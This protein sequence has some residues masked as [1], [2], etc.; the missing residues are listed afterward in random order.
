MRSAA[1]C[2]RARPRF[3]A[4]SSPER[5]ACRRDMSTLATPATALKA[6]PTTATAGATDAREAHA[7]PDF[8]KFAT[9]LAQLAVLAGVF[10]FFDLED[11]AFVLLAELIIVGFAIHYWLPFA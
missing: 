9:L 6:V 8:V 11:Q 1:R 2:T 7:T 10:R 5:W 3:S 4:T